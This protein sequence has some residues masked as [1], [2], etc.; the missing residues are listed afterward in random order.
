MAL[1]E[2]SSAE[3]MARHN[4]DEDDAER[5]I[6][7]GEVHGITGSV[8]LDMGRSGRGWSRAGRCRGCRAWGGA[9]CCR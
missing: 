5:G 2:E 3:E 8:K 4:C 1:V 7:D 6:A 9:A